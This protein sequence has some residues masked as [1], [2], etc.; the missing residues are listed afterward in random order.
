MEMI[1]QGL[2]MCRL[3]NSVALIIGSEKGLKSGGSCVSVWERLKVNEWKCNE[4][5]KAGFDYVGFNYVN[6][7][8]LIAVSGKGGL[9]SGE[10]CVSVWEKFK[11]N[12]WK[13]NKDDEVGFDCINDTVLQGMKM[14]WS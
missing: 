6:G 5:D 12:E 4:D 13:C 7:I 3:L 14:D 10:S 1:R 2:V 9:K 11:V 8:V